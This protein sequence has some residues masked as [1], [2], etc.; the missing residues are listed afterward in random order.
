MVE[1]DFRAN[2]R[3][4]IR[5]LGIS[6]AALL[7]PVIGDLFLPREILGAHQALLWLVALIPAFLLAYHR[8]W[9]GAA[10]ALAAGMVTLSFT[11]AV[12]NWM[13]RPVPDLL[14]GVVVAYLGLSLAIGWLAERMLKDREVVE[15]LAFTDLLTHLPNRRHARVFLENEFAAAERGRLLSAVLFDLD[16]FKLYNDRFGHAAGDEAL[17]AFSDILSLTTRRMNLSARFGGE[18]FLTVLAG[19]DVEG[20]LVF[21]ERVRTS[22]RAKKLPHGSLTVSAGV[23]THHPSM[24]SPDELIAAAD[25]ALYQAKREGRNRVRLFGRGLI[26]DAVAEAQIERPPGGEPISLEYPRPAEEIG[27]SRPPVTLLPHKVTGFGEGRKVLLVEDEDAVRDLLSSYLTKEGFSVTEATDVPSAIRD[28]GLEFDVV[29]TDLKLPGQW[30][31][32]LVRASKAR[33]PATQVLAITGVKDPAVTA[34]AMSEGADRY[35]LKPFGMPELR[36]EMA[37]ALARRDRAL[38]D[39]SRRRLVSAEAVERGE[40]ARLSILAGTRSL[41]TAAEIRDPY[42]LGHHQKV[43]LYARELLKA[44]D[45]DGILCSPDSLLQG[46]QLLDVGK[47][48]IP[49]GVLNKPGPLSPEEI[50]LVRAHPETGRRILDPLLEDEIVLQ[51]VTWHHERWDGTGYPHGLMGDAIPLAA[52]V[53]ALADALDAMTSRRAYREALDWDEAISLLR[54]EEGGQFDPQVV[55]ALQ[56]A[57]PGLSAIFRAQD[58]P[59]F[60]PPAPDRG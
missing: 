21:A 14:A 52:R 51:V 49:D 34:E 50:E 36:A 7:V 59:E 22:L 37:E 13:G 18:E 12:A 43:A 25:H 29:V 44:L 5:A 40:R 9:T 28:L 46:A 41:V 27:K 45:P 19:S 15:D 30:G 31:M 56:T 11:Q 24:R 8:G 39:R 23:A 35:L 3:V 54:E 10:L 32:E 4:P 60:D 53:V 16:N 1:P 38:M 33:W 26:A 2:Q 47:I 58:S 20:A 42:T 17:R 6:L 48:E 55:E 57:L